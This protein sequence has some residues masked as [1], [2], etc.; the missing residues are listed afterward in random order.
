MALG[1]ANVF[2]AAR[3]A[4]VRRV[5]F[6]SSIAYHG[7]QWRHGERPLRE[8]DPCL[9]DTVYGASKYLGEVLAQEYNRRFGLE[10][11]S[12]RIPVVYGPGGRLG[13]HG[14]NLIATEAALGRPIT[15]PHPPQDKV[16]IAHVEDVAEIVV[17]LLTAE[18][19]QHQVYQVGGHVLS[20]QELADI[21]R[22]RLGE[23]QISFATEPIDLAYLIDGSRLEKEL[24]VLHRDPRSAYWEFIDLTRKEAGLPTVG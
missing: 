18:R 13:A 11:V 5:I 17:R 21:A 24:G 10:I 23:V 16:C 7:P 8:E 2:E 4:A 20:Y 3:L 22:E 9:S 15:L 19:V 1:T 6:P 14:V 12:I